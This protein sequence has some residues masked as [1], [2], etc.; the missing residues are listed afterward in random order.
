MD[1]S[2]SKFIANIVAVSFFIIA[3]GLFFFMDSK[4]NYLGNTV[5]DS[6]SKSTNVVERISN[7]PESVDIYS[8]AY[9]IA[10]IRN[11]LEHSIIINDFMVMDVSDNLSFDY[12][13]IDINGK[14]K[15]SYVYGE[16]GKILYLVYVSV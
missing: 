3:L 8:G 1:E 11:G 7:T 16:D 10:K 15:E 4:T 2:I 13:L 6:F 9:L 12:S 14:Y 5:K